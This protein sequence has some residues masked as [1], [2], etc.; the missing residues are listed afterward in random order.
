MKRKGE[1]PKDSLRK[2]AETFLA[3]QPEPP[4]DPPVE[5]L[6]Q[7]IHELQVHQIELDMQNE[8]L[9]RQQAESDE[10]KDRYRDL[11]DFA[12]LGYFTFDPDGRIAEVNLT[13]AGLLDLPRTRLIGR[14]FFLFV[15]RDFLPL[16]R[17]HLQKVFATPVRQTCELKIR[18]RPEKSALY[19]AIE[20]IAAGPG[21][22]IR[23]RSAVID[24][25]ARKRLEEDLREY[26]SAIENS[27]DIIAVVDENYTYVMAN[28]RFLQ[29]QGLTRPQVLGKTIREIVGRDVFETLIQ[30]NVDACLRGKTVQYEMKR[31]YP[32]RGERHLLVKYFPVE[33]PKG[34]TRIISVTEDITDRKRA[35]NLAQARFRILAAGQ[36]PAISVPDILQGTLDEIEALTG[37]AI[38]FYHFLEAAH[39]TISLQTWSTH[40]LQN[41]CTA[42]GVGRHYPISQ[43]GVWVDAVRERRP[44]IHNDLA[45]LPHR[46]GLPPGHAP[47]IREMV[48]PI[49]RGGQVVAVIGVGNKSFPY[50]PADVEIAALLGDLSWE[51]VERR[52]AE[53]ALQEVHERAAWLARFPEENSGP[54]LRVDV[55]GN[56]LY[57]N[58]ASME[59][60]GWTCQVGQPLP[61]F[62]HPH[63]GPALSKGQETHLDLKVGQR[64]YT[65]TFTPF[66]EEGY[67]NIYG[68]DTSER[69]RTVETLRKK[70]LELQHLTDTLELRVIDRASAL[71]QANESLR[72]ISVKLLSAQEDERKRI[73]GEIHDTLGSTLSAAKF[74][75]GDLLQCGQT[76][77]EARESL[78]A[79]IPLIQES[80]DECRRIQMDLRPPMLDDL[81]LLPTLSWFCRRFQTI[82]SG[83]RIEQ[84]VGLEERDL[85]VPLKIVVFRVT[86]EALN[87]IAK[88]SQADR[89][90]LVLRKRGNRL[91][92]V[93]Q[94][95]GQGFPSG[96]PASPPD[97]RKG[98]GL[99]SMQER[100]EFSGGSFALRST[101]G[102]GTTVRASWPLPEKG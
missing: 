32:E 78:S 88:Y 95:N 27:Q 83:I 69:N 82:Y 75:A 61:D 10:A 21:E 91:E 55:A 18:P 54:V 25:S 20:S 51:I 101:V 23:C 89:V 15:E 62:L 47:V 6:Q 58:P 59:M 66:S 12:P 65:V 102:K 33:T 81:G 7:L 90:L 19:V 87:N 67:V 34:I 49:L 48:V 80:I 85:P 17:A 52:R 9:R 45:S 36:A 42:E 1:P 98:L 37:S 73:A 8:E 53:L 56:V 84:E 64:S 22:A 28:N 5:S 74:K 71:T 86:Q 4:A 26:E 70:T 16:F 30:P 46:R 63:F 14:S 93:I 79:I 40:T 43:A 68:L 29:Y 60:H 41:L 38:G 96:N 50:D 11:F 31:T 97:L 99:T 39:E 94:D 13:G 3:R 100:I 44:V 35:D 76:P 92:L 72:Q 2:K 24:V 77:N 57:C